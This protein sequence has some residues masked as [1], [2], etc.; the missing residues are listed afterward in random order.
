[1]LDDNIYAVAPVAG[2]QVWVGSR[3]GVTL[4]VSK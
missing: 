1:L 4:L 3:S 2:G